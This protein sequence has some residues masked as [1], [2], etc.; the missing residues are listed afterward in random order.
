MRLVLLVIAGWLAASGPVLWWTGRRMA[1]GSDEPLGI[2]ALLAAAGFLWSERLELRPQARGLVVG[3]ILLLASAWSPLPNLVQGALAV[4][5]LGSAFGLPRRLPGAFVLLG[6]AL[7]WMASL[8]FFCGPPLREFLAHG[9]AMILQAGGLAVDP[10]GSVL[11]TGGRPVTV[12]PPCSGLGMLWHALFFS[13]ALSAWFR[14]PV[15]RTTVLLS[16][17]TTMAVGANILRTA[18]LFFPESGLVFWPHWT[19]QAVGLAWFG[20]A[21][22]P[23]WFLAQRWGGRGSSLPTNPTPTAAGATRIWCVAVLGATFLNFCPL[24]EEPDR[25]SLDS[26]PW[27]KEWNDQPLSVLPPDPLEARFA[28]DFPGE[29]RRFALPGG[30]VILRR[31]ACATRKLHPTADCLRAS[32]FQLV[33]SMRET[34]TTKGPPLLTYRMT[35]PDGRIWEVE[36]SVRGLRDSYHAASVSEWFWHALAHPSGG[37]WE[38]VTVMRLY[39]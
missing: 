20:F 1:D 10:C 2:L 25:G 24:G 18:T 14:L 8:D 23:V 31:V 22:L 30:Q 6:L 38:A 34:T 26:I 29:I 32:G 13:A 15:G 36:E 9:A 28:A 3:A 16:C 33:G 27:P 17:T 21:L 7:P 37:P 5:A 39:R 19:H 4:A 12:D 11:T 35:A